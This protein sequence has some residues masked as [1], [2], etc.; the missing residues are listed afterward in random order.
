MEWKFHWL[1]FYILDAN[2]QW[3]E[4]ESSVLVLIVKVKEERVYYGLF[5]SNRRIKAMGFAVEF[6]P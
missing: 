1:R 2:K 3:V 5:M 4:G 6:E